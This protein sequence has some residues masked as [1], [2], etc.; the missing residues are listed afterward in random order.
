M[1]DRVFCTYF[2]HKYLSR[3]IALYRSLQRHAP[4]ARLW[5][6]CPS[7]QCHS[8]GMRYV[9]AREAAADWITYH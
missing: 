2:D 8:V 3:D 6:L 7:K 5:V 4:G 1:D 9:M